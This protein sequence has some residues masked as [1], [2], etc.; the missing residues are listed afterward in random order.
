MKES[1]LA[2]VLT[3][4]ILTFISLG[5]GL[6][7]GKN[8]IRESLPVKNSSEIC[9]CTNEGYNFR[10]YPELRKTIQD[11]STIKCV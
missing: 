5:I 3:G 11:C 9:A 6:A 10:Y 2:K 1:F 7:K 4:I 8:H